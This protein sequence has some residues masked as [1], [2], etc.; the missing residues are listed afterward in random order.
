MQEIIPTKDRLPLA[1]C[2]KS[3]ALTMKKLH[4]TADGPEASLVDAKAEKRRS[5]EALGC[6]DMLLW[7]FVFIRRVSAASNGVWLK[8][9]Y[10]SFVTTLYHVSSDSFRSYDRNEVMGSARSSVARSLSIREPSSCRQST[11]YAQRST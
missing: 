5:L 6:S 9:E 2:P 11:Q 1:K 10:I 8:W 3:E 7:I 4:A